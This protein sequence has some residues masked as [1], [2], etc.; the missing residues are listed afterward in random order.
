MT[1]QTSFVDFELAKIDS[2]TTTNEALLLVEQIHDS[3]YAMTRGQIGKFGGISSIEND[4]AMS[5][6][7]TDKESVLALITLNG[8]CI[9]TADDVPNVSNEFPSNQVTAI[10]R[11]CYRGF[12]IS[13][14]HGTLDQAS[15]SPA[16]FIAVNGLVSPM[17]P[18]L[19]PP[20]GFG[21][22]WLNQIPVPT[23]PY[24]LI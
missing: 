15:N 4:A 19:P 2:R 22:Q 10:I 1:S 14:A 23:D 24:R 12:G 20:G 18:G 11:D 5:T 13:G 17:K 3:V 16:K 6:K 7:N 21:Q 8:T 9:R